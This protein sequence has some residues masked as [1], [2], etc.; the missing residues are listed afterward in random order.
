MANMSVEEI[1]MALAAAGY[2]LNWLSTICP[3][4]HA[5]KVLAFLLKTINVLSANVGTSKNKD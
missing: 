3:N 1:A 2:V 4:D 5:N